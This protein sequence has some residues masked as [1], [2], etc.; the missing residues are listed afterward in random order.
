MKNKAAQS[1]GRMGKGK[2][3]SFTEAEKNLR[4]KRLATARSLRWKNS[5]IGRKDGSNE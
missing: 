2:P 5:S 4:R 3:K 1:L